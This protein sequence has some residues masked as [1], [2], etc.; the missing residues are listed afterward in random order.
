MTL[1]SE[2]YL[3]KAS[4]SALFK[5]SRMCESNMNY[6]DK[7]GLL[8][9]LCLCFHL[10]FVQ[11]LI[12]HFCVS[13]YALYDFFLMC[14][15]SVCVCVC[16]CHICS[17]VTSQLLLSLPSTPLDR[18]HGCPSFYGDLPHLQHGKTTS[19]VRSSN[20]LEPVWTLLDTDGQWTLLVALTP[21]RRPSLCLTVSFSL[22]SVSV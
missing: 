19:P 2:G 9:Y 11:D 18:T 12:C 8:L 17:V 21:I 10:S 4:P 22:P 15:C 16:V 3:Q 5:S 6:Q 7:L 1:S 20:V 14:V 13:F